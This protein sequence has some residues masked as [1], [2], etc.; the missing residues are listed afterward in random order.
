MAE[1]PN[2][3]GMMHNVFFWDHNHPEG[4]KDENSSKQNL[5][6]AARAARLALYLTQQGYKAG[7]ITILTPYVGMYMHCSMFNRQ[8]Y[9]HKQ[10]CVM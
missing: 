5:V 8:L 4:G 2:V 6:E 1:Y 9:M 3:R 7:D 10:I